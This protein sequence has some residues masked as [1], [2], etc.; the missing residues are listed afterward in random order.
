MP[1]T[2]IKTY[3]ATCNKKK[4]V[5]SAL[6]YVLY[7]ASLYFMLILGKAV[8][9]DIT[10]VEYH[11]DPQ[12]D[13]KIRNVLR[14]LTRF[15]VKRESKGM[16]GRSFQ[17]AFS[18]FAEIGPGGICFPFLFVGVSLISISSLTF[19]VGDT[20]GFMSLPCLSLG[21][22]PKARKP[23]AS[24][25]HAPK[26]L[27]QYHFRFDEYALDD[28]EYPIISKSGKQYTG[29][30]LNHHH[31]MTVFVDELWGLHIDKGKLSIQ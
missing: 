24:N 31:P 10:A 6:S 18:Q 21:K 27:L 25:L 23:L 7:T 26:T 29:T 2:C 5:S 30:R 11:N 22:V 15:R 13:D 12:K 4:P 16:H 19:V 8:A 14:G 28:D 20:P 1:R 17:G 3:L 9:L